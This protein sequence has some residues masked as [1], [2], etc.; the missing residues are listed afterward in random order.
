MIRPATTSGTKNTPRAAWR[1]MRNPTDGTA[2]MRMPTSG[3]HTGS[4]PA[5]T[6]TARMPATPRPSMKTVR[7]N[8]LESRMPIR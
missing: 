1:V 8:P 5:A 2:L 6:R 7:A 4:F 3:D